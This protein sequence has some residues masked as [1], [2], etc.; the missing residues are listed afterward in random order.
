MAR[1]Y[2]N[3]GLD[4]KGSLRRSKYPRQKNNSLWRWMLVTG[5][6]IA[7][8]VFLVYLSFSTPKDVNNPVDVSTAEKSTPVDAQQKTPP[9]PE[10]KAEPKPPHF[11][12]YTVLPKKEVVVSENEIKTRTREER[13][14]K[15]K[16]SKYSM[17]AGAF[18]NLK[19]AEKL[20][21]KLAQMGIDAT[22]DKAKIGAKADKPTMWYRVKIGPYSKMASVDSI[23]SRLK[24]HGMN[25]VVT[26]TGN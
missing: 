1:D 13:V 24:K 2:K 11:E 9:K 25:V 23:K 21:L 19:D 15:A 20:R 3:R 5:L 12:F 14:G 10:E 6:I 16:E 17:Q 26:E 4:K 7:F 8:V 18:Q 22:V